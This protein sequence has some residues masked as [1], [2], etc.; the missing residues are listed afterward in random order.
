[1]EKIPS[2][3]KSFGK[4][5]EDSQY[6]M[7]YYIKGRIILPI[8]SEFGE[9]VAFATRKPS[10]SPGNS[11]WNLP[12]K[13]S[14]YVF[15]LDK[16]RKYIFDSNKVYI[17]EGYMDAILLQQAGIRN[18]VSIMGT[19]LTLRKIGLIA[20]YCNNVCICM[21][22]DKNN[23]GQIA[24]SSSVCLFRKV[25]FCESISVIDGLPVGVDPDEYVIENGTDKFLAMEKTLT[26]AEIRKICS[27][28]E[29]RNHSKAKR[30]Y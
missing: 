8:Y 1:G 19:A 10:A 23:A 12:F 24:Q 22:A 2:V 9:L 14:H 5:N 6:D 15:L 27:D 20:R 3:I 11:W 29:S 25:D 18:V 28:V 26:Q 30:D 4:E 21:D 17:V 7:S 16:T 13:K